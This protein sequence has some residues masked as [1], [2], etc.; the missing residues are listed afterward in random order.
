MIVLISGSARENTFTGDKN[1]FEKACE[2]IG[3]ALAKKG[4]QIVVGSEEDWTADLHVV[5][6]YCSVKN[7]ENL[8]VYAHRSK[9]QAI[10]YGKIERSSSHVTFEHR[11]CNGDWD[12]NRVEQVATSDCVLLIGGSRGTLQS[13]FVAPTL[14]KRVV[15]VTCFG[16]A[17]QTVWERIEARYCND[18]K[19][20]E[21][22][23][24]LE[25]DWTTGK[26]NTVVDL[27]E[28][29]TWKNP[30]IKRN[31]FPHLTY[32]LT[33]FLLSGV[34][35]YVFS[36][37]IFS[38][39]ISLF[40]LMA[41]AANLGTSVKNALSYLYS[42]NGIVKWD[43][44]LMEAGSALVVGMGLTWA[45]F[46]FQ[47]T[48][49]GNFDFSGIDKNADFQRVSILMSL[50]GLFSGVMLNESSNSLKNLFDK[51]IPKIGKPS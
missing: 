6:G 4:H 9:D 49:T 42:N 25:S 35:L 32:L 40:V 31:Y 51:T 17:A 23:R 10:P 43:L 45:Y 5:K 7:I 27:I 44:L 37:Q 2:E 22:T 16:G 12:V 14:Q 18:E 13:G 41:I 46:V 50:V 19:I 47:G 15:A 39:T 48:L 30:Y 21:L 38:N 3:K 8:K 11:K 28:I 1:I 29:I 33:V 36:N 26:E 24:Q 20:L 34:W